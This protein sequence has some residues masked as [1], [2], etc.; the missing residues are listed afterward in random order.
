MLFWISPYPGP[1]LTTPRANIGD[2]S[3]AHLMLHRI[4]SWLNLLYLSAP[5]VQLLAADYR[6]V[7]QTM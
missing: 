1:E 5:A 6:Q 7:Q 2:A 4:A 3:P